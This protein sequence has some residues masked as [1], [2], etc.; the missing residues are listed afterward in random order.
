V[1]VREVVLYPWRVCS[2]YLRQKIAP[3]G[4]R[5]IFFVSL[6]DE[7]RS[8][9]MSDEITSKFFDYV[10]QRQALYI[11]RLGEAVG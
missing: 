11:E 2:L 5:T 6:F 8:K 1:R 7:K 4:C 3:K 9:T 10:D